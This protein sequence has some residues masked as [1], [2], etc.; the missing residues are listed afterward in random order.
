MPGPAYLRGD[1]VTLR[2][3]ERG[4]LD[5]LQEMINRRE[6][7]D[8]FGAPGPRNR[9]EMESRFEDQN[10]GEALLICRGEEPIGRVR[11]VDVDEQ[12]GNAELTC[13]VAPDAQDEG[14]ATEACSVFVDYGFEYLPITKVT[15]RVFESNEASR[16]LAESL[17]FSREGVLRD[18]VYHAGEYLDF[19][20]YGL[21][22]REWDG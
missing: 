14:V 15:A 12:W 16:H 22:E 3:V 6:L 19:H 9:G 20:V 17:G 1:T 8:G 11:F 18:H 21:L 4:D 2:T 10:T 13:F 7:W 5:F